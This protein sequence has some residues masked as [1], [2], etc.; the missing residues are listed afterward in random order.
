[1]AMGEHVIELPEFLS[2]T[3]YKTIADIEE[4]SGTMDKLLTIVIPS[5][6]VEETLRQTVES[7]LVPDMGAR[8]MLDILIVN[9]GSKD[10][11]LRLA[12]Q[13]EADNSGIVRVWDKENGGHGSTIN[14]GM[15]QAY[16][17]Y[18]KIVDG[19]DW[20]ETEALEQLLHV[21]VTTNVDMVA[22]DCVE[23]FMDDER[24]EFVKEST[25]QYN[26]NLSFCDIWSSYTFRM[27]D[28]AVKTELLRKQS[29]RID[30]HCYYVDQEFDTL[31]AMLVNE[32]LY[33]N[34]NLYVY[35]RQRPNQS[36]SVEGRIKH[37][38]NH[39][40]VIMR[41]IS[42]YVELKQQ[43]STERASYIKFSIKKYMRRHYYMGLE[44]PKKQRK[45]FLIALSSFDS[46]VKSV[47]KELYQ[48]SGEAKLIKTLRT[49]RFSELVYTILSIRKKIVDCFKNTTR[50]NA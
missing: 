40:R 49:F 38:T 11:T 23:Y 18:L 4:D 27:M 17:K 15:E 28:L 14:V 1:M 10:G 42:W 41:L 36:I 35:R 19:D 31:V 6:N 48:F 2:I 39:E 22:T 21:L 47:S 13:L 37:Y 43:I 7:M 24:Y 32:I 45:Q 29:I 20:L 5:Y 26:V 8:N 46:N 12:K 9:D 16:G 33:K 3:I 25:L 30:E 34:I 50:G 44:F